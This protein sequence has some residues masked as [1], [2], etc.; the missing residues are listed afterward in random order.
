M[1]AFL[2]PKSAGSPMTTHR[3]Q[4]LGW[5]LLTIAGLIVPP[6]SL[7]SA[8][9]FCSAPS[10]TLAEQIAGSDAAVIAHWES[11]T[12]A[13]GQDIGLT[14]FVVVEVLSNRA[15]L[16]GDEAGPRPVSK[17]TPQ[18]KITTARAQKG[19]TDDLF[20]LTA[21]I[22]NERLEWASPVPLD[23]TAVKYL[24]DSPHPSAPVAE[25]LKFFIR[26]LEAPNQLVGDDA[27]AEFANAPYDEIAPLASAMP[28]EN[29]RKWL[30]DSKVSPSRLGL[31]G[32]M[33]GLC[34]EASDVQFMEAKI[35]DTTEDFRLGIDGVMGGYLLLAGEDGLKKLQAEKLSNP[36]SPFSETYSAM[37]ALRFCW[38]Y[39]QGRIPPESL[40]VAMRVLLSRP[41][42]A[43]LVI[44]DLARW[45]DWEVRHKLFEQYDA[46][47]FSVPSIKRAIVRY[48]IVCSKDVS[49]NPAADT[50]GAIE[51]PNPADKPAWVNEAADMLAEIERKDPKTVQDAKRFLF[52][53]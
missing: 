19:T 23:A 8:C 37:Q 21:T 51:Q 29:L 48:L 9:P 15:S 12:P 5:A 17:V 35:F 3:F 1:L 53:K 46:P 36:K 43:D 16:G 6:A 25:R 30:T 20:L 28:R 34:G 50:P 33:L 52:L 42:L 41:E 31:Y 4:K 7:A 14:H 22:V 18:D 47:E 32:L 26:Y 10:L 13:K 2:L 40:K 27:Y 44:A 24:K 38:Q 11:E 39:G 45:K 49:A